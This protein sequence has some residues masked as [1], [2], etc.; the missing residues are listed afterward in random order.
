MLYVQII[1]LCHSCKLYISCC[2]GFF[3]S[4]FDEKVAHFPR[5]DFI[6]PK[7]ILDNLNKCLWFHWIKITMHK[8]NTI[9]Y[10]KKKMS[11]MENCRNCVII[12]SF[13]SKKKNHTAKYLLVLW[14]TAMFLCEYMQFLIKINLIIFF[15]FGI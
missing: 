2:C 11:C 12:K 6:H 9:E 1:G 4:V 15:S 8:N 3:F 13:G 5:L 7:K 14:V 10:S